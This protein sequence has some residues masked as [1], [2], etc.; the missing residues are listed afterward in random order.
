MSTRDKLEAA[1]DGVLNSDTCGD[2]LGDGT[3]HLTRWVIVA[4][5]ADAESDS[6]CTTLHQSDMANWVARGLLAEG[7]RLS[8]APPDEE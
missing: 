6:T 1:L 2:F 5:L 8:F 7:R 3:W 4:E